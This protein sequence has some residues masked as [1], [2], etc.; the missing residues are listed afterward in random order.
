M[1]TNRVL[2]RLGAR[3][4]SDEEQRQVAAGFRIGRSFGSSPLTGPCNY[5]PVLCR[6]ISG[7]CSDVPPA[8]LGE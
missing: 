1:E 4:L 6:V 2:S 3:L 7:D 5:D 8:C